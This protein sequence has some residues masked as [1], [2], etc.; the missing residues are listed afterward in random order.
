MR[1][2]TRC[3]FCVLTPRVQQMTY[4]SDETSNRATLILQVD[5]IDLPRAV[6]VARGAQPAR[7]AAQ[8][9]FTQMLRNFN[10]NIPRD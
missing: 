10:G 5:Q 1:L 2:K 9:F 3:N 4:Y 6:A 7:G 8:I